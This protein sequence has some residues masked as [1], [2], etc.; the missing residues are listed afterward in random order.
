VPF[1]KYRDI[2]VKVES[3]DRRRRG[4]GGGEI[5]GDLKRGFLNEYQDSRPNFLRGKI[6]PIYLLVLCLSF[7]EERLKT[8]C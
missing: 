6:E 8:F 4:N 7:S 1:L 5:Q 2:D 3:I